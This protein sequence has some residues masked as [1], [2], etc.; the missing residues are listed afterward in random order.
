LP[1]V[2]PIYRGEGGSPASPNE[3]LTKLGALSPQP[4]PG[5]FLNRK[6]VNAKDIYFKSV[7]QAEMYMNINIKKNTIMK[8]L[9]KL[10]INPG[11]LIKNEDLVK[12]KGG[13][14]PVSVLTCHRIWLNG[15][16][17]TVEFEYCEVP[18]FIY[19]KCN[20]ICPDWE[21]AICSGPLY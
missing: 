16:P 14:E 10:Q 2:V 13:E 18:P 21:Y 17:C 1:T 5:P 12:F 3:V 4:L 8:K 9:N 20:E 6:E 11:R 19:A 15:G 7:R